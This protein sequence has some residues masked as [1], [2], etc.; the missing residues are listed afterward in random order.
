MKGLKMI[1]LV[2][3]TFSLVTGGLCS[4]GWA[5]DYLGMDDPVAQGWSVMD[6]LIARPL[7]IIAG[8]GGSVIFV[9]SLPFTIPA[10]GV[11]N[12]ADMLILQ[13]FQF[14]FTRE[15]PDQDM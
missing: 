13:P 2:A 11:R 1:L 3:L 14:S 5:G 9:V 7:G 15:F 6:L 12:A 8:L 10:G 4:T